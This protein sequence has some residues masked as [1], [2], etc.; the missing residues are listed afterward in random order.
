MDITIE[1]LTDTF[2]DNWTFVHFTGVDEGSYNN[3][4]IQ[5]LEAIKDELD[6]EGGSSETIGKGLYTENFLNPPA[7]FDKTLMLWRLGYN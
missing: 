1:K 4:A 7:D 6:I 2:D 5:H 3:P